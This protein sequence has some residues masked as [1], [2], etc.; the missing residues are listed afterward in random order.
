MAYFNDPRS[1][2]AIY[3]TSS[4]F[5]SNRRRRFGIDASSVSPDLLVTYLKDRRE[6][7]RATACELL[8]TVVVNLVA[9]RVALRDGS[10]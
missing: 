3:I 9:V 5:P 6:A 7:A 4:G 8:N 1:G 2:R 10:Q